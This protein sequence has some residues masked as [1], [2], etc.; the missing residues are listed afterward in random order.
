[1]LSL[2]LKRIVFDR[3]KRSRMN[4]VRGLSLIGGAGG[5]EVGFEGDREVGE[6]AVGDGG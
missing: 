6:E 4:A 3:E 1:M 5:L 2:I